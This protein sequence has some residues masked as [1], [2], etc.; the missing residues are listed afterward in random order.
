MLLLLFSSR[1]IGDPMA[2]DRSSN[3]D[4]LG[5][6]EKMFNPL[7][8]QGNEPGAQDIQPNVS[9]PH[10]VDTTYPEGGLQAWLVVLGSFAG[11]VSKDFG[12]L[13]FNR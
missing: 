5:D 2:S 7:D 10:D 12:S 9:H 4:R 6:P 8:G 13:G 11:M 3:D 1:T